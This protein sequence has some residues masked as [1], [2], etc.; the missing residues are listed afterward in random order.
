MS[1]SSIKS[2]KGVEKLTNK[3]V[4]FTQA[5]DL[6][7]GE[8]RETFRS[9]IIYGVIHFPN[10]KA[11]IGSAKKPKLY[12]LNNFLGRLVNLKEWMSSL[13]KPCI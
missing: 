2:S 3:E 12:Y 4:D 9:Q 10:L 1:N 8:V 7:K 13:S 6:D 5:N 11:V